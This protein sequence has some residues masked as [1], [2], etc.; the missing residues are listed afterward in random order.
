MEWRK[1]STAHGM[2][3]FPG[4]SQQIKEMVKQCDICQ[5]HR[6]ANTKE[7][8]LSHEILEN[9]VGDVHR[10]KA[11]LA[12]HGIP[13]KVVSDNGSCCRSHEFKQ[14]AD[15]WGFQHVTSSPHYLQSNSLVEKTVLQ[16]RSSPRPRRTR[17][18]C[19][20]VCWSTETQLMDSNHQLKS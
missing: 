12:R 11:T 7:P 6:G 15:S 5:T 10:M 20:L 13:K 14:F 1:A 17:E 3:C 19:T 18:T 9:P 16:S 4:M 8:K 2:L